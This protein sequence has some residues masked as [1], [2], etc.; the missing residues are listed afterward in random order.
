MKYF[1]VSYFSYDH[2]GAFVIESKT[3]I[4]PLT[5]AHETILKNEG[6]VIP[7][8]FYCETTSDERIKYC[9]FCEKHQPDN[10]FNKPR[11]LS[12]VPVRPE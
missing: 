10:C 11:H 8:L 12:V 2:A 6:R 3:G 7:I 9:S 1:Y 5:D 4:F